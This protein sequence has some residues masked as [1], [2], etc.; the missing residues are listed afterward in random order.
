MFK[1]KSQMPI[2]NMKGGNFFIEPKKVNPIVETLSKYGLP[3]NIT[4]EDDIKA[5]MP[6]LSNDKLMPKIIYISDTEDDM[7]CAPVINFKNGSCIPTVVL[8]EMV[9]AYNKYYKNDKI[10]TVKN[11]DPF[12][13]DDYKKY[14]LSEMKKKFDGPQKDWVNE[15]FTKYM[16]TE[17]KEILENEIFRP[18]GPKKQFQ[19]M[20]SLD[21]NAVMEQY[22]KLYANFKFLG[23]VPIDFDI[24][25]FYNI[26]NIDYD[27]LEKEG[28]TRFGM[29]INNQRHD[30]GGQ[31]WFCLFF[32]L[33]K[34]DIFFVDSVGE[35]PME[36]VEKYVEKL[37]EYL[38][39]KNIKPNYKINTTQHQRKNSECGIY[40][41]F[42][43]LRFLKSG[44]FE[45]TTYKVIDDDTINTEIRP[46]L[47][48]NQEWNKKK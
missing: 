9:E 14:L 11:I 2:F 36:N 15:N 47:F 12:Y 34:G 32:D 23:S 21:M 38:K 35:K 41:M 48:T 39:S 22:E 45:E 1:K 16:K 4:K 25:E 30:Q 7:K 5:T 17:I 20:S 6:I 24:V 10:P 37:K 18:E 29:I 40:S 46:Y 8:I 44:N 33:K 42:F 3:F 13:M 19:W 27:K 28:K 43:I 31:H 26:K